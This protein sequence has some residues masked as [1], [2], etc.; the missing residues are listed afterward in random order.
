[1]KLKEFNVF[2]I[3]AITKKISNNGVF[4]KKKAIQGKNSYKGYPKIT[5]KPNQPIETKKDSKKVSIVLKVKMSKDSYEVYSTEFAGLT[6]N[7]EKMIGS[8]NQPIETKK[9]PKKFMFSTSK[10][11]RSQ[12]FV[13][14]EFAG[15]TKN[16]NNIKETLNP[17]ESEEESKIRVKGEI[18]PGSLK[19]N[20]AQVKLKKPKL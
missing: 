9:L 2:Y 12:K 16:P 19:N 20:R 6:Q 13:W 17:I 15:L 7:H 1:M 18:C 3:V 4:P 11:N 5:G 10:M 8:S 14:V